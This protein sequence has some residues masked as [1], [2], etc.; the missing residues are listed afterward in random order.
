MNTVF[1]ARNEK[2]TSICS[3]H[4]NPAK[5]LKNAAK[6]LQ[7]IIESGRIIHPVAINIELVNDVPNIWNVSLVIGEVVD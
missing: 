7:S 3:M 2:L 1:E 6:H 4:E 5:A